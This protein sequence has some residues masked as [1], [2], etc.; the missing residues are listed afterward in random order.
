MDIFR[1]WL[2]KNKDEILEKLNQ[3]IFLEEWNKYA[4]GN[5]SSWEMEVMCFY[6]HDH[7]LAHLDQLKYGFVDFNEL[8]EDPIIDRTFYKGGKEI[9]IFKLN[10]ICGTCI[11]KDKA[12]GTVTLLT[13]TGVV[14]VKFRK[15][16]FAMFDKQISELGADGKKHVQE[17]SWFNR[18]S[19]I[20]VQGIRSGDQ[21]ITKKYA[22]SGGHQLYKI[23]EVFP[24]GE[25]ALQ[26]E[27]YQGGKLLLIVFV[28]LDIAPWST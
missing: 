24:N 25:I 13:P 28:P 17:K 7:E 15:E 8:P 27:R 12:K 11:A 16:Y 10:K 9:N 4:Y 6:Y 3:I 21:F 23:T 22:N 18:G 20:V 2:N 19:M 1:N 26:T 14:T 5:I